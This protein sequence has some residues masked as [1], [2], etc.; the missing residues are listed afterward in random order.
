MRKSGFT[1]I[2]IL[3]TIAISA[4]LVTFG[5]ASYIKFNQRQIVDQAA[6]QIFSDLR[7]AQ[8]KALSGEKAPSYGCGANPLRGWSVKFNTSGYE[9]YGECG[10]VSFNNKTYTLSNS[11]NVTAPLE[12]NNVLTFKP[13]A[14]G[15]I[16][17]KIICLAGLNSIYKLEVTSSGEI[18]NFGIV[19]SCS[20][21]ILP[22]AIPSPVPH[23][24]WGIGGVCDAGC[25][26]SSTSPV[27]VYTQCNDSGTCGCE[28]VRADGSYPTGIT[29]SYVDRYY[30]AVTCGGNMIGYMGNQYDDCRW[31]TCSGNCYE[32]SN[33]SNKNVTS[34]QRDPRNGGDCYSPGSP[35]YASVC[36]LTALQVHT[37]TSTNKVVGGSVTK[38]TGSGTCDGGGLGNCYKPNGG[39]T[40]YTAGG[41]GSCGSG[42]Y[43][44]SVTAC[45]WI[46]Y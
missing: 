45:S 28:W 37:G 44:D 9:I 34:L 20:A 31:S 30:D 46:S 11:L 18:I 24:C 5:L 38:Y 17:P 1:L 35:W 4:L 12:P 36:D 14:G 40:F 33:Y 41:C 42:T 25:T 39:S 22:T 27:T 19:E 32:Q 8:N 43:Y 23:Y 21:P 2:E 7:L 15:V 3:V 10:A 29:T 26:V 13:L 6:R 16:N